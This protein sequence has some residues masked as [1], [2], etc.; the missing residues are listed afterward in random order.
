MHAD[1]LC[2]HAVSTEYTQRASVTLL[3]AKHTD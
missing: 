2:S 1:E 3:I